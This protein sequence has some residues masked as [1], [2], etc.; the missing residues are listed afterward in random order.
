[1]EGEAVAAKVLP[2]ANEDGEAEEKPTAVA[3]GRSQRKSPKRQPRNDKAFAGH[4]QI[5][6]HGGQNEAEAEDK[7]VGGVG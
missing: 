7:P 2:G 1:M 4:K 3:N 5:N 6:A